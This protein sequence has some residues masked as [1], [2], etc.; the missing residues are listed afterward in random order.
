[1]LDFNLRMRACSSINLSVL[2]EKFPFNIT[3]AR[4]ESEWYGVLKCLVTGSPLLLCRCSL[5]DSEIRRPC[6][7]LP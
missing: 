7:N 3:H 2:L 5:P 1:M 4:L 6:Q